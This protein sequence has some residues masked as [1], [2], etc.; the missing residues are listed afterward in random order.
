MSAWPHGKKKIGEDGGIC[1]V[2]VVPTPRF[3]S[4]LVGS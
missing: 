1:V 3:D 2:Q 4:V